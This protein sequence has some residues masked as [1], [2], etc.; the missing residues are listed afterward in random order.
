MS[1]ICTV[2]SIAGAA[3]A[4]YEVQT[5]ELSS[6]AFIQ[7]IDLIVVT[8]LSAIIGIWATVRKADLY[9]TT[10]AEKRNDME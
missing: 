6:L 7:S 9:E 1:L 5:L 3:M 8:L 4:N 2:L 10:L